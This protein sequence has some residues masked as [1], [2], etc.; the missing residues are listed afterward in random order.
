[1]SSHQKV[2]NLRTP[3]PF[4][5]KLRDLSH[6]L[7]VNDTQHQ[8]TRTFSTKGEP[9]ALG[10]DMPLDKD[11]LNPAMPHMGIQSLA[12]SVQEHHLPPGVGV[13]DLEDMPGEPS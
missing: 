3:S 9:T 11:G 4:T 2:P 5:S 1:M 6:S 13:G 10:T 7:R 12:I 8:G